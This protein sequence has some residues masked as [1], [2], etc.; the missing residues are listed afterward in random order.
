MN[1]QERIHRQMDTRREGQTHMDIQ[2]DGQT[3]KD[4][5]TDG[6]TDGYTDGQENIGYNKG[7][8]WGKQRWPDYSKSPVYC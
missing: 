1:R 4:T 3:R 7:M 6:Q 8:E 2:T 5:Q